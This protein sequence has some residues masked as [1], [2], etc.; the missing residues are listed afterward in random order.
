MRLIASA[1]L[2]AIAGLFVLTLMSY[3]SPDN[4][5]VE[6]RVELVMR[7][8]GHELLLQAGDSTSRVLPVLK[9]KDIGYQLE[10]ED[11]LTFKSDSLVAITRRNIA[12]AGLPSNH[13]ISVIDRE[14]LHMVFGFETRRGATPIDPCLGR[15]QP[16]GRYAIQLLFTEP[17]VKPRNHTAGYVAVALLMVAGLVALLWSKPSPTRVN[18]TD[19]RSTTDPSTSSVKFE[20]DEVTGF[21]KFNDLVVS[22]TNKESK[23]LQ[24]LFRHVN[25]VVTRDELLLAVWES[26]GVITGRS[27]DVFISKLR[28]KFDVYSGVRIV[29]IHGRGYKLE[30]SNDQY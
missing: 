6:K 12:A 22:L 2:V 13:I 10:F 18:S 8:I 25:Q 21:L 29:N 5:I 15:P 19:S 23:V 24:T 26:E 1:F 30:I 20:F 16:R 27:L 28:K 7:K 4:G 3:D 14:T 9:I 17:V 11:A